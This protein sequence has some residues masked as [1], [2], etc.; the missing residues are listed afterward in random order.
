MRRGECRKYER[1]KN[2]QEAGGKNSKGCG[3]DRTKSNGR[4]L[5]VTVAVDDF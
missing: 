1:M 2:F 4:T 3:R 5:D